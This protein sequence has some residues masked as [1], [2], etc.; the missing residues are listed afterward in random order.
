MRPLRSPLHRQLGY[1]LL[2]VSLALLAASIA[3]MGSARSSINAFNTS[4]GKNIGNQLQTVLTGLDA[5]IQS[6]YSALA[7]SQSVAGVVNAN[8]PT[9][10]E[11]QAL[12]LLSAGVQTKPSLGNSYKINVWVTPTGC[13]P[14]TCKVKG[15]VYLQDPISGPNN[16]TTDIRL[17]S[18]AADVSPYNQIGFSKID[19]NAP[20]SAQKIY[21]SSGA[22]EINPDA[23]KRA[24]ILYASTDRNTVNTMLYWQAPI[25]V[26]ANLPLTNN[27][28]GDG[29]LVKY[30]NRP[31]IYEGIN[32]N[33]NN[34]WKELFSSGFDASNVSIGQGAG[35]E[36]TNA[37]S[38]TMRNN[39][40]MGVNAGAAA[41]STTTATGPAGPSSDNTFVGGEAGKAN[42]GYANV[43]VGKSAG[44]ANTQGSANTF[45][46]AEAGKNTVQ[47]NKNLFLGYQAG[48]NANGADGNVFLGAYSGMV[49]STGQGNVF[50]GTNTGKSNTTGSFNVFTGN[51]A[52]ASNTTGSRNVYN[53]YLAGSYSNSGNDNVFMGFAAGVSNAASQNVFVGAYAGLANTTG[54]DNTII[55]AS[56]GTD[57]TSGSSNTFLGY[58]SGSRNTTGDANV[59]L[60]GFAGYLGQTAKQNVFLGHGAGW[61]NDSGIGNTAI[62][63]SA[64]F[65]RKTGNYNTSIGYASGVAE[66]VSNSTAIGYFG[67]SALP[68]ESNTVR[69]GNSYVSKIGGAVPW[70]TVSDRRLKTNIQ[71]AQR[72]L[73]FIR[74]L[75]P[76]DYTLIDS[77]KAETGFIAQ[78]VE[79]VDPSFPGVNKPKNDKAYY[80]VAYTDFVPAI[81]KAIQELDA[82]AHTATPLF[83]DDKVLWS[84]AAVLGVLSAL[85]AVLLYAERRLFQEV[86]ALKQQLHAT[87]GA[88]TP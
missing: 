4:V 46:G 81:V 11:L 80:S 54:A 14:A 69:I 7:S 76:V 34:G 51:E 31:Y 50:T 45:L 67:W 16:V 44:E 64:D 61:N 66:G 71:D 70:S 5:Y 21:F 20:K 78:E 62:G 2:G 55:G 43:F 41:G 25:D 12:N 18:A 39:V 37:S 87:S 10:A 8:A 3:A 19:V 13:A 36:K 88:L 85:V 42:T 40:F 30:N 33:L 75:R 83:D 9:V 49:N 65:N 15:A 60:G 53:G 26:T 24:G 77:Q 58:N 86:N 22:V 35:F 59:Y 1:Y 28:T 68:S 47:G 6:N 74:Q 82:K 23:N 29:R 73:A 27:N 79:A 17:L 32:V 57:N 38:A 48:M 63:Y 84:I 72:G 56:A 52:G